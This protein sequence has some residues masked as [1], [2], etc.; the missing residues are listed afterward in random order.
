VL[1]ANDPYEGV[2]NLDGRLTF[3]GAP[4]AFGLQTAPR[5]SPSEAADL[6]TGTAH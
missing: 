6:A 5:P 3:E 2:R 4:E 1:I